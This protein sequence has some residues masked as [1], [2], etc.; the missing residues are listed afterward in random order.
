MRNEQNAR[1]ARV[2]RRR[3]RRL[4]RSPARVGGSGQ[5]AE[6]RNECAVRFNRS[7]CAVQIRECYLLPDDGV[8]EE[9]ELSA[10]PALPLVPPAPPAA[11]LVPPVVPL[12]PPAAPGVGVLPEEAPGVALSV[13]PVVPPVEPAP[14]VDP[15][16]PPVVPDEEEA[17]A[18]LSG[19]VVP[20]VDG[21]VVLPLLLGGVALPVVPALDEE[22]D[23]AELLLAGAA[24]SSFLPHAV[25]ASAA[26]KVASNT[27]YF[28]SDPSIVKPLQDSSI[29]LSSKVALTSAA[30]FDIAHRTP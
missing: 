24:D 27:E 25:T 12:E 8:L 29:N 26:T 11:P 16:A 21:L 14:P 15:A 1:K 9:E 10:P 5:R 17:P 20:L 18:L 19:A 3:V 23:G 22:P 28:I 4:D 30:D 13:D 2:R 7:L 6:R